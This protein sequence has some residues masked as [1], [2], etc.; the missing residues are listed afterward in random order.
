MGNQDLMATP[1]SSIV[2]VEN[3]DNSKNMDRRQ[4]VPAAGAEARRSMV[5]HIQ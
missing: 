3:G 5:N 1:T 2:S 4:S